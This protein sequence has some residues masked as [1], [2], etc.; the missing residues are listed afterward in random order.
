MPGGAL[1]LTLSGPGTGLSGETHK[2]LT[3]SRRRGDPAAEGKPECRPRAHD[4][5]PLRIDPGQMPRRTLAGRGAAEKDGGVEGHGIGMVCVHVG[6][7]FL[8]R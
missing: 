5:A 4:V 2:F 6:D 8:L 7:D 1:G 3:E